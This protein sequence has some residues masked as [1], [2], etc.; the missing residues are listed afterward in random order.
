[1][2]RSLLLFLF[3]SIIL[4]PCIGETTAHT[5]SISSDTKTHSVEEF[6]ITNIEEY[7]Y[8]DVKQKLEKIN[9]IRKSQK[10]II[11]KI[12]SRFLKNKEI[13]TVFNYYDYKLH[14]I[15]KSI[16]NIEKYNRIIE[17][18]KEDNTLYFLAGDVLFI[19]DLSN[20]QLE[21]RKQIDINLCKMLNEKYNISADKN[22]IPVPKSLFIFNKQIYCLFYYNYQYSN[23]TINNIFL[24]MNMDG[25]NI[26]FIDLKEIRA[27]SEDLIQ[28]IGYDIIH[29]KI[30][31]LSINDKNPI[32][33]KI[34]YLNY[35]KKDNIFSIYE[36]YDLDWEILRFMKYP[37]LL[38]NKKIIFTSGYDGC[39]INLI[40]Y[41]IIN[42]TKDNIFKLG[43]LI[44]SAF[45]DGM[46]VEDSDLW[47]TTYGS[48]ITDNKIKY[49]NEVKSFF[50]DDIQ[51]VFFVKINLKK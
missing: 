22:N 25:S 37:I 36:S 32:Q 40:S 46:Y 11:S 48:I 13:E 39:L 10:S 6:N 38:Y 9:K 28:T 27:K 5:Y 34:N 44:N 24:K 7:Y 19:Y 2:N 23:K 21:L 49:T 18:Y 41:D 12:F 51:D 3:I 14:M 1:M 16:V 15:L 35:D 4:F 26:E 8:K 17:I 47:I 50:G 30:W 31:T 29:K 43:F 42:K 33:C 20:N 45:Y